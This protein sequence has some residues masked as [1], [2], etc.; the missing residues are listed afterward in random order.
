M[1]QLRAVMLI[2]LMT[3]YLPAKMTGQVEIQVSK[4]GTASVSGRVLLKGEPMN[5]VTVVLEPQRKI[6]HATSDS[7]V[8]TRTNVNGQYQFTGLI[9]G[10]YHISA[11]YPGYISDADDRITRTGNVVTLADGEQIENVNIELKRGGVIT[12]RVI[13]ANNRPVVEE[14][15]RLFR[16]DDNGRPKQF[17]EYGNVPI[18]QI[19][20]TDDR[21]IYRIYGLPEGRYLASVGYFPG[22]VNSGSIRTSYLRTFHPD[23]TDQTRAKVIEIREGSEVTDVD[24]IV[25]ELKKAY[26]LYG[27]VV[28]AES[29]QPVADVFLDYGQITQEP[30]FGV[31]SSGVKSNI[32]GEFRIQ[33]VFPGKY[34]VSPKLGDERGYYGD[35]ATV[36]IKDQDLHGIEVR[37]QNAGSIS[38]KVILEGTDDAKVLSRLSE[39]LIQAR[40]RIDYQSNKEQSPIFNK[41][42]KVNPDGSF[43]IKG[44]P[45]GNIELYLRIPPT[46]SSVAERR[47]EY[48]GVALPKGQGVDLGAGQHITNVLIIGALASST[49]RGEVRVIGVSLP[50]DVKLYVYARG[51]DATGTAGR[52]EID[53]RGRFVIDNIPAGEYDLRVSLSPTVIGL[54]QKYPELQRKLL[55]F[56]QKVVVAP[57]VPQNVVINLDN[58]NQTEQKQ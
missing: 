4:I 46:L 3:F 34:N 30:S 42:V 39:L 58:V 38:G 16:L 9:A 32:Q 54:A 51:G 15:V 22:S 25:G 18:L 21:G 56:N 31:F 28:D 35:P 20:N 52:S 5:D 44:L 50:P 11:V 6:N 7:S 24:I 29:G 23:T 10:G 48:N 14:R 26:D 1:T 12:G 47:I 43:Q 27:R 41:S 57:G 55:L 40:R 2:M 13:D 8:K 17:L 19:S 36:E 49:V 33:N 45:P 37:V 53:E